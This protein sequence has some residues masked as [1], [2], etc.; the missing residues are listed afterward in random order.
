MVADL[1]P[2]GEERLLDRVEEAI[3]READPVARAD[4]AL[5]TVL[6]L[7]GKPLAAPILGQWGGLQQLAG[8]DVPEYNNMFD[9]F[10]S[11]M[12]GRFDLT[13]AEVARVFPSRQ[14]TPMTVFA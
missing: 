8:G 5:L 7:S 4:A 12:K 6:V 11:I 9:V 2:G 1:L 13:D 14:F 10:G 3:L